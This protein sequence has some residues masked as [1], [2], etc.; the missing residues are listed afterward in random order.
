M[1]LQVFVSKHSCVVYNPA[2]KLKAGK[3]PPPPTKKNPWEVQENNRKCHVEDE[4][5]S[6]GRTFVFLSEL[7]VNYKP[8]FLWEGQNYV[9]YGTT[10]SHGAEMFSLLNHEV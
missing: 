2:D 8:K 7:P 9:M 1:V 4:W 5:N 6:S 3:Q 10:A